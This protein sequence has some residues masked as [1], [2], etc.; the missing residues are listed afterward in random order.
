MIERFAAYEAQLLEAN[1]RFN[2]TRITDPEDFEIRVLLDSLS[3]VPLIPT[4]AKSLLD[5]GSGGGVPGMVLAIARPDL[6]VTLLDA[7][8]KKVRFLQETAAALGLERVVA[9]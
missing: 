3:L 6:D 4:T 9:I 2:L 8:G 5:V 1:Q 7:T